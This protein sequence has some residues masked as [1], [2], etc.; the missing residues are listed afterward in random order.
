VLARRAEGENESTIPPVLR[1]TL[2]D[3]KSLNAKATLYVCERGT[4]RPPV[5][6]V[7]AIDDLL[8]AL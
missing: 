3:K 7:Q 4:C 5:A 1:P 2:A 8:E 6:G